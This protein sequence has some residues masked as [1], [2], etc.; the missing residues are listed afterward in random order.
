MK[1]SNQYSVEE[2]GK[3]FF[4]IY[5]F[6]DGEKMLMSKSYRTESG[7]NKRMVNVKFQAGVK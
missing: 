3:A 6:A 2:I 7:A 4:V 5:T 1:N